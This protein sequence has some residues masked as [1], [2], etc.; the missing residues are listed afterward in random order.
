VLRVLTFSML[1][2]MERQVSD[3]F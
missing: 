1:K 2:R 3:F